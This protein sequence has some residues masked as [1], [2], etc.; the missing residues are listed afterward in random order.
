MARGRAWRRALGEI[1]ASEPTSLTSLHLASLL[2]HAIRNVPY[3]R[4]LEVPSLEL[5][6][7]PVLPRHALREPSAPLLSVDA[8]Q[9]STVRTCTGGSTGEPVWLLRDRQSF[10]WDYATDMYYMDAFHATPFQE[11]LRSRRAIIWHQRGHRGLADSITAAIS[12]LLGQVLRLET[13]TILSEEMLAEFVRRIQRH[14][15]VMIWA[16]A[17]TLFE[18][19]R[20]AKTKGLS[21]PSPRFILSS[22]EMLYPYM[23]ETIEDA[24][25]CRVF[26]FYGSAEIGHAAAECSAGRLHAFS[27][28]CVLELLDEFDRPVVQ[29]AVG[30]IVATPL[31]SYAVP[32]IRY[33][34]GD[35]ARRGP[36][37]CPCGSPLPTLEELVGRRIEHFLT[38][39]GRWIYGGYFVAMFYPHPWVKAFHVLQEDFDLIR[40]H[41]ATASSAEI[42]A[43]AMEEIDTAI[44]RVMGPGCRIIWEHVAE[45]PKSALGKHLHTRSLVWEHERRQELQE[46]PR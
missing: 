29:G 18:I 21:I 33:D 32:L 27:F 1:Q 16:F 9:R 26:N 46:I 11:Y 28:H 45:I 12:S 20:Y 10:V 40:I 34:I 38:S 14:R 41:C 31:H 35:T 43:Q 19:A 3:Y 36:D 22:V 13:Y 6:A 2:D 25:G 4:G 15:P 23:R 7:F 30:R 44:R 24:F 39:D 8:Q 42:P 37:T 5:S 17:G